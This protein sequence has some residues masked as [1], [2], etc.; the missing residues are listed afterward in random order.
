[1][2]A[3]SELHTAVR[4]NLPVTVVVLDNAELGVMRLKQDISGM[5]RYGTAL[6]GIDWE[7]LAQAFGADGLIV[8][9]ENALGDALSR[10]AN[11]SRTTVIGVKVDSSGYVD[12]Y[13]ALRGRN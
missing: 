2:V 8:E 12:Q 9:N 10:A 6:G 3:V 7:K 11:S 5:S 4:E 1:M 13:N